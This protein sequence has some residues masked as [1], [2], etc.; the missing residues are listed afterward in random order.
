MEMISLL[1]CQAARSSVA[2]SS[3]TCSEDETEVGIGLD[4]RWAD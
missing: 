1:M 2:P 4:C 3:C